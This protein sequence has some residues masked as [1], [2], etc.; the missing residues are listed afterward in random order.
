MRIFAPVSEGSFC[1]LPNHLKSR[2][3]FVNIL[4]EL[5]SEMRYQWCLDVCSTSY[6]LRKHTVKKMSLTISNKLAY[7]IHLCE[8]DQMAPIRCMNC[9]RPQLVHTVDLAALACGTAL[10]PNSAGL[11]EDVKT[12]WIHSTRL[13][14]SLALSDTLR[15]CRTHVRRRLLT[16]RSQTLTIYTVLL[17]WSWHSIS[18]VM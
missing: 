3:S 2:E 1:E 13:R 18:V 9:S 16:L 14:R 10:Q 12:I 5:V 6:P 8:T 4:T 15:P 11:T 17:I 7:T